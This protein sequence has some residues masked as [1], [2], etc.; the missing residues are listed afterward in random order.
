MSAAQLPAF[1]AGDFVDTFWVAE[2]DGEIVGCC[3]LE[4]YN[5]AGLLRSAVVTPDLRGTG[6]GRDLT[7][8]VIEGASANGVRDLYLF[9][10]DAGDFFGHMGFEKCEL[11]DFSDSG[12]Q[13]T[14]WQ[15]VSEHPEVAKMLTAM[16][17]R[18]DD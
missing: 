6:L 7:K 4:V 13:S 3:G 9:T 11:E 10:L 17:M 18:L 15:A 5:D 14:Q 12:R 1:R 8:A 2:S 16:R